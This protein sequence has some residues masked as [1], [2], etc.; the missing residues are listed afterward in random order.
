[1]SQEPPAPS[2]DAA[3]SHALA[4]TTKRRVG[5]AFAATALVVVF[6]A[7]V[8]ATTRS[9]LLAPPTLLL[10]A[11]VWYLALH[12]G[13]TVGQ[14]KRLRGGKPPHWLPS[15]SHGVLVLDDQA[16]VAGGL[17]GALDAK[18]EAKVVAV[19]YDEAR[20]VIT[21]DVK[22]TAATADGEHSRQVHTTVHFDEQVS[23]EQAAAFA[24]AAR[25]RVA[26]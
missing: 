9:W 21:V 8:L 12:S 5:A 25:E 6:F 2:F 17:Y 4:I 18:A 14:L 10:L 23:A 19:E 20:H 11:P 15:S 7:V 1:M 24:R 22:H 26:R 3:L 16:L 13:Q